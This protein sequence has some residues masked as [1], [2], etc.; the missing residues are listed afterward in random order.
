MNQFSTRGDYYLYLPMTVT[1][2]DSK[3]AKA[4]YNR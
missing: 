2:C 1:A 4:A 3:R